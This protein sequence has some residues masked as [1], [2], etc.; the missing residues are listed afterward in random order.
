M[1]KLIK[2]IVFVFSSVFILGCESSNHRNVNW[3]A[4][5]A[6]SNQISNGFAT[7]AGYGQQNYR[8]PSSTYQNGTSNYC[9]VDNYGNK[10]C[11]YWDLQSCQQAARQKF[12]AAACVMK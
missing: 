1:I 11:I 3:D 5:Q 8:Q 10:D 7:G 6:G 12:G 2:L 4:V 9:V